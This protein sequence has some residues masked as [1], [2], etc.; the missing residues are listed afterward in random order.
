VR[1]FVT[2]VLIAT[3][4]VLLMAANPAGAQSGPT[5]VMEP[6]CRTLGGEQV[7][8]V[9]VGATGLA[10]NA[11]L[12][13]QIEWTYIVDPPRGGGST[14]PATF[15]SDA[16]GNFASFDFST[17]GVKTSY[18]ATLVYAGQTFTKTLAVTCDKPTTTEQCKNG[19][20]RDFGIFKNQG[21]CVSFVAT[22]GKSPPAH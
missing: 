22:K 5:L 16:N 12:T 6:D 7:Y 10:P 13:I 3:A 9:K 2:A 17:V 11:Q 20:W 15:T 19:R 14:S 21:D 18:T 8:G 4:T 1:R